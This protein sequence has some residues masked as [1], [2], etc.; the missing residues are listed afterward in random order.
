M[1]QQ[2]TQ[3]NPVERQTASIGVDTS[4]LEVGIVGN[5]M[6]THESAHD[7]ASQNESAKDST[8][9]SP[10]SCDSTEGSDGPTEGWRVFPDD[11]NELY[12]PETDACPPEDPNAEGEDADD[13][14]VPVEK[15]S[16]PQLSSEIEVTESQSRS[17]NIVLAPP[18]DPI[19]TYLRVHKCIMRI[20]KVARGSL[21]RLYSRLNTKVPV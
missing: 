14:S 9:S 4:S 21:V 6:L 3:G 18:A 17:K 5:S 15:S 8:P 11:P 16:L 19:E 1:E 12:I 20:Q 7:D 13:E 10:V 2:V